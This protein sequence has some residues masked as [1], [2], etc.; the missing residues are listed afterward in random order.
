MKAFVDGDL[1][2]FESFAIMI[3]LLG[4]IS[5]FIIIIS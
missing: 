2:I 4:L 3:Y 5:I 1:C